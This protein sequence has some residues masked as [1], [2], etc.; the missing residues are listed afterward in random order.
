M[1][2]AVTVLQLDTYFPRIKGDVGCPDSYK[3]EI[4]IIR[5]PQATVGKI[6]TDRPDQIDIAPFAGALRQAKGHV[7]VTSCGFL[8]Y[9]Q[10]HLAR[11]IDRPF[12]S[13][14]LVAL[15]RLAA[16]YD[17]GEVMIVTFDQTSL[18]SQ[19]LRQ[20]TDYA[21]GIVGLSADSHLRQVIS[22]DLAHLDAQRAE[23]E[24]T[25]D[26]LTARAAQHKH[27]L[28]ECTNLPPYRAALLRATGLPITDILTEVELARPNTVANF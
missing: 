4:E 26:V 13:S 19:H 9:W 3:A 23:A 25:H 12:I 21:A 24:V 16:D 22:Q 14:S 20:Y 2:P 17:P 15:D 6:V 7:V 11:L 1:R 28:L 10:D 18:T 27:I 8:S 5:I